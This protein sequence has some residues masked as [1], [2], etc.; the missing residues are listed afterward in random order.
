MEVGGLEPPHSGIPVKLLVSPCTLY[1]SALPT[2]LHL[3][4][5]ISVASI[6]YHVF[7]K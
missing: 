3:H 5:A 1:T 7:L 6:Y 4:S 2:E